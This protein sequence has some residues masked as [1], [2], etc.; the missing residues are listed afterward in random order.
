M[1]FYEN[2]IEVITFIAG[3]SQIMGHMPSKLSLSK[4]IEK[5]NEHSDQDIESFGLFESSSPNYTTYYPEVTEEDFKPKDSDFIEPV[6]RLLSN[7]VVQ[8]KTNPIEFPEDVLKAS[9]HKL[10]GLTVNVDH[11]TALGNGIGVIKAVEWQPS[12]KTGSFEVPGGINGIL[13]IDGKSNPRIVRGIMMDP[14]MIHSN[15]VTVAFGWRPSHDMD[16]SLFYSKLGTYDKDGK[17]IR[18]IAT[19]IKFYLE[20]SLVGLGADPFAQKI[21][22]GKIVNPVLAKSRE[23]IS[24]KSLSD[25][26][27]INTVCTLDWKENGKVL[28]VISNSIENFNDNNNNENMELLRFLE[29]VFGLEQNSLTEENYSERITAIAEQLTS[30]TSEVE[31]LRTPTIEGLVGTEAISNAI[32]ELATLKGQLPEGRDLAS[33]VKLSMVGMDA[34]S[35]LRADTLRLYNLS[36]NGSTAD[37]VLVNLINTTDYEN[38][39]ALHTQYDK[40]T[41][42]ALEFVCN[43]CNSHNVTRASAKGATIENGLTPKTPAEVIKN[44]TSGIK[45]KFTIFKNK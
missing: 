5:I 37:D 14:P 13:K 41:D 33:V 27:Y 29:T 24:K 43:D 30:L 21:D 38:L 45:G 10:I 16:E 4:V 11:E 1:K 44:A 7:T 40:F 22:N 6:Y 42:K 28:E 2:I 35:V 39:K 31:G 20:T 17:L 19:D 15:S 26:T 9:M 36:L 3:H 25:D 8:H 23:P 18:K 12:Y 32:K 34:I